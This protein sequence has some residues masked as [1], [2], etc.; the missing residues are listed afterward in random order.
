MNLKFLVLMVVGAFFFMGCSTETEEDLEASLL[1]TKLGK[2]KT[3]EK[4]VS[5]PFKS[6]ASGE[7]FFEEAE[8]EECDGLLRYSIVGVGNATHMGKIS[9]Q[10]TLCT[11][12]PENIYI[13]TVTY[14]SANGDQITWQSGDIFLNEENIFAG[15]VFNCIGGTGRFEGAEGSIAVDE[16][17]EVTLISDGLPLAGT[18]S[19]EGSGIIIY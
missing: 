19:N 16:M 11:F 1:K 14:T 7:W 8:S 13:I 12:P 15:G 2:D 5:R 18:F 4:V 17:L 10:G 6:K 9:I 3:T